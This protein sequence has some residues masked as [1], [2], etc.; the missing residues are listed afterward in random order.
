MAGLAERENSCPPDRIYRSSEPLTNT[1]RLACYYSLTLTG[2]LLLD[3]TPTLTYILVAV[4]WFTPRGEVRRGGAGS[5]FGGC[6]VNGV[7][8]T[9][10]NK[11]R[12]ISLRFR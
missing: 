5:L 4:L 2:I 1:A 8:I 9:D 6:M 3:V 10:Q 12:V 11:L 7:A